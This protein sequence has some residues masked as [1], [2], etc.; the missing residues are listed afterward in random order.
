MKKSMIALA[1]AA[2][3]TAPLMVQAAAP[4][5]S[6]FVDIIYSLVDDTAD[7]GLVNT[8]E[9][10]FSA[11]G[12]IDFKGNLAED[13]SVQV[14]LDVNLGGGDSGDIEQAFFALKATD[15]VSVIGGVFN[16]PIGWEAEDAPN[17]Y[18]TSHSMN[19]DLLNS[20]T[21]LR[22]NN[23]AGL[24]VAGTFDTITVTAA[25]LNDLQQTPEENSLAVAVGLAP[26]KDI[27]LEL[28]IVTQDNDSGVC[29][30]FN[31]LADNNC[32][33]GTVINANGS[34]KVE[35]GLTIAAEIML[36]SELIDYSMMGMVNMA[37]PETPFSVTARGEL[38]A[39]DGGDDDTLALTFAGLYT[40][41]D[42]L[43]IV[44]EMKYI[45]G[46]FNDGDIQI[47]L[48]LIASF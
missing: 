4:E 32:G 39:L 5:V 41:N 22:G 1:V 48:E 20:Q 23:V 16:S 24:A 44:A 8:N 15:Q 19:Y 25:L 37:V 3:T 2:A 9:S 43:G 10:Q 28:G 36:A 46:D 21:A 35:N 27:E 38:L 18:Q 42:A 6:G 13:V 26:N 45:D 47:G 12:E 17:M 30:V 29:T 7:T 14:D 40:H 34:F 11:D 31:S 33:V